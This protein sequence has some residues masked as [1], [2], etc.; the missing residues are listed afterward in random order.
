MTHEIT[1]S[2]GAKITVEKIGPDRA[3]EILE[4]HNGRNRSLTAKTTGKYVRAIEANEWPF[5]GDPIRFDSKGDLL[6]GQHRL[7]AVVET[8]IVIEFVVIH[9]IDTDTQ[10]YMDGGRVRTAVDQLKIEGMGNAPS[11]AAIASCAMRWDLGDVLAQ[12]IKFST[13][14]I[15]D[16]VE[17]HL[18]QVEVAVQSANRVRQAV[19]STISI[20]GAA[21]IMATRIV[22]GSVIDEFFN[23]LITGA[24][25][26]V[27]SPILTLRETV[28]RNKREGTLS[29]SNE[30][31]YTTHAWNCWR[32]GKSIHK[33]QLPRGSEL[34]ADK[35]KL[36]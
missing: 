36:R 35:L 15:V 18:D 26:D 28:Q 29:R 8:G 3:A 25:L 9:G 12:N 1:A 19:G 31:W 33:L 4:H 13:F 5:L 23:G 2:S 11:A 22:T 34:T 7:A 21:H 20:I 27:G 16:W 6:D 24:S 30:L 17:E 32:L 14:E 10:K